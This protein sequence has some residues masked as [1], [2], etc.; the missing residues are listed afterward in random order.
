MAP[1]ND[2][3]TKKAMN[4]GT[5]TPEEDHKLAHCIQIHGATKWKTVALNSGKPHYLFFY[6]LQHQMLVVVVVVVSK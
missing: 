2:G 1:K 6:F 3:P 4:R 5:W